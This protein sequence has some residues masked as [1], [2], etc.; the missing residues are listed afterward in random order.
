[1][2]RLQTTTFT[3]LSE[4]PLFQ[5]MIEQ[6]TSKKDHDYT[7]IEITDILFGS[8]YKKPSVKISTEKL[9]FILKEALNYGTPKERF[10]Q[11]IKAIQTIYSIE[12]EKRSATPEEQKHLVQYVGW[13]GLSDAFDHSKS[14]WTSEY[15]TLQNLLS[16][17][18]YRSAF[19]S[20]LTSF[21]T[22]PAVIE[23]IYQAIRK[24]G[25]RQGN[26]LDPSLGTGHFFGCLPKDFNMN[27]YGSE[28]DNLTARIASNLYPNST[29]FH[30]GYE[31]SNFPDNFFD[32]VVSNVPFGNYKIYDP[33]RNHYLV[34]DYFF[35]RSIDALRPGGLMAFITSKGTLDK[36]DSSIR[37]YIS[38]RTE[39]VGA[40]RLPDMTFKSSSGT[41]VTSDLI[42]LKKLSGRTHGDE[43]WTKVSTNDDGLSMNQYFI[44]NP[45]QVL[46]NM[47][48]ISGPFGMDTACI[49][50]KDYTIDDLSDDLKIAL[51]NI[52]GNLDV[53]PVYEESK[54]LTDTRIPADPSLANYSFG[55]VKGKL[56]FRENSE[57][58]LV[59]LPKR[60]ME[61]INELIN[62]RTTLRELIQ[63]QLNDADDFSILSQQ[64]ILN[65]QYD[66]LLRKHGYIN[67][68]GNKKVFE[69][70][71]SYWL[72]CSLE[73][74]NDKGI[75]TGKSDI[76]T[77]RTIN[78]RKPIESVD[79]AD[80][81]L[82][83]SMSE[84][85]FIDFEYMAKLSSKTKEELIFDLEESIFLNPLS[86]C[87][88]TADSYLSGNV[89]EKL[90]LALSLIDSQP[91]LSVNVNALKEVMPKDLDASEISVFLGA[92]WIEPS[93]ILDF[94]EEVFEPSAHLLFH[95]IL[96]VDYSSYTGEWTIDGKNA[97]YSNIIVNS[98]YGTA[99]TNAYQLL[100]QA[101]NLKSVRIYD[102]I[103][104][105]GGTKKRVFNHKDTIVAQ[106]KQDMIK[107]RF[108]NWIFADVDRR[109]Y[110]VNKY[111]R[112]FNS[113]R[114]RQ[115]NSNHVVLHGVNPDIELRDYQ[116]SVVARSLFGGN[117]LV[118][119]EVGAGK[120]FSL[121]SI[122]MESIHLSLASKCLFVV[123]NH[124]IYQW[125]SEFQR[126]YPCANILVTQKKDFEKSRRKIFCSRVAT[127]QY[128]AIIM[129]HSQ[130]ERIS[131]S[132]ELQI[133][134][135]E[136]E[137]DVLVKE[138]DRLSSED[139]DRLTVKHIARLIKSLETQLKTLTDSAKDNTINFEELGIDRLLVDEAHLYKNLF[140]HTKMRN[141]SGV[142]SGFSKKATDLYLKCQ[143]MHSITNNKGVIF[144]TGTPVSNT[145]S[146]LYTFMRYLIPKRLAKL[147]LQHFDAWASIFT[148]QRTAIE[149]APEGQ[150]YQMKTRLARF[151]NLPELMSLINE[152][153]DIKVADQ[154]NLPVPKHEIINI[155]L[156]PSEFQKNYIQSLGKRAGKVRNGGVD[157]QEDNMLLITNDGRKLA[158]DQRLIDP[159][160]SDHGTSKVSACA[161]NVYKIWNSTHETKS[162]QLVFCDLSTPNPDKFNVYQELKNKLI[163]LSIPEIEIAFI[164][165]AKTDSQRDTLFSQVRSGQIRILMGSTNKLGIGTCIQ[166]KC[167]SLH[168]LDIPWK[169]S[170]ITQQNGRIIRQG[171]ENE[172]VTI[173]NYLT[174][175]TFDAYS[176]QIIENKQ[177]FIGQIM[178]S[179]A[180]TRSVDDIDSQALDYAEIKALATG[181]PMIKE[182]I[183]LE[184]NIAQLKLIES[185]NRRQY[186]SLEDN[187]LHRYPKK[188]KE[189]EYRL[190]EY[191]K[192]L[193]LGALEVKDFSATI[194]GQLYNDRDLANS[195][196]KTIKA[197]LDRSTYGL[198][199]NLGNYRG[200]DLSIM[201][202]NLTTYK[203][204]IRNE[205]NYQIDLTN[206]S[207]NF[208]VLDQAIKDIQLYHDN[209]ISKIDSLQTEIRQ[210]KEIL[211][212]PFEESTELKDATERLSVV[213][214]LLF[215]ED[216]IAA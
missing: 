41:T 196:L 99:R 177:Y 50:P 171:N 172:A 92:T 127:C 21:Y 39:F 54:A 126:L 30:G 169:P 77:K 147:G 205:R 88:E 98:T 114:T 164:H 202:M 94:I 80:E 49:A 143:Y 64:K 45:G 75:Y 152:F 204:S 52:C 14:N 16:E 137:I 32:C 207:N 13:G 78:A 61:R 74:F 131:L 51:S 76:F 82:I 34:H 7:Q 133:S 113:N 130:F 153:A 117:T 128:D 9:N 89:R 101:L 48:E 200:F 214:S 86:D 97:D 2:S 129:G 68:P 211:S 29:I 156:K 5:F 17:K 31:D 187:V 170:D 141:V 66:K 85:G 72:L 188:L 212:K 148:E 186:Y 118:A 165:D 185:E 43:S 184:S 87:Y 57:M 90:E 111:N 191:K 203:L 104:E 151:H 216:S 180:A 24:L 138:Y 201:R 122:A 166:D 36:K 46:G 84:R 28:L 215:K 154:L 161:E 19:D 125:A 4:L 119:H 189:L 59:V 12:K 96:K 53:I 38:S 135:M 140:L 23:C 56:Y 71:D 139:G 160:A 65:E 183:E 146:E 209:T 105:P 91:E 199:F 192:D 150:N 109:Q 37:E 33:K 103:T 55:Y 1:M 115:F 6:T 194:N 162:T 173:Y 158:L 44:E 208:D 149:L 20:T 142:A 206:S 121:A 60:S 35:I 69:K 136:D 22:P 3:E 159:S 197:D 63:M 198:S 93:Y 27:L 62:L 167:V 168:R 79:T 144:A 174:E 95:N 132:P 124:L 145:I 25:Y 108:K 190:S 106:Q 58:E 42:F 67:S 18:E 157:P 176:Y 112:L 100:E 163:S 8:S 123:P 213:N 175:E 10:N 40:V 195:I 81:A 116:K 11:N 107:D 102:T 120:T 83:L 179:K 210:A 70:D 193:A 155:C 182:K 26:L 110:L 134:M 178:T 73:V 15:Q 181:N 47:V